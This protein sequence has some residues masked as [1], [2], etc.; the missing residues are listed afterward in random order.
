MIAGWPP[1]GGVWGRW[2][3][4]LPRLDHP[5]VSAHGQHPSLAPPC[6]TQCPQMLPYCSCV[7][8]VSCNEWLSSPPGSDK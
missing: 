3:D 6:L 7:H 4:K 1:P 8:C 5:V 2:K